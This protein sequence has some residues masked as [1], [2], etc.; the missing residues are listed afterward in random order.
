MEQRSTPAYVAE[1]IGTFFLVLFILMVVSVNSPG[2]LQFTDFAVIGLG[3][4]SSWPMLV[5]SLGGT[6]RGAFQPR[7]HGGAGRRCARSRR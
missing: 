4:R 1:F 3:T 2:G 7:G 5:Y 6:L